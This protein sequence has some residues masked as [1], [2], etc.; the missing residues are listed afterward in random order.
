[1][2]DSRQIRFLLSLDG[3]EQ[4]LGVVDYVTGLFRPERLE[5]VLFHVFSAIPD[6]Y[7]DLEPEPAFTNK[8]I[9]TAVSES[10]RRDAV[11]EFMFEAES[12]VTE[13]GLPGRAIKVK[14]QDRMQDVARD[15]AY[16]AQD[17]YLA[18]V[19]GGIGTTTLQDLTVGSTA[20]KLL[21][22]LTSVNMIVVKGRP[23]PDRVLLAY[24]GSEGSRRALNLT[25]RLLS[26]SQC[27]ITVFHAL[28]GNNEDFP[29]NGNGKEVRELWHTR[30]ADVK[31]RVESSLEQAREFLEN[32]GVSPER[33]EVKMVTGVASRSGAIFQEALK[34]GYGSIIV[35][36]KGFSEVNEFSMG[37]VSN[38]LIH[39]ARNMAVWVAA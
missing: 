2:A 7:W 23:A 16:E 11:R 1:M 17:G 38:K 22:H 26:D 27:R 13:A 9:R 21:D 10:R 12:R 37:R 3:S 15:I 24:D 8:I 25:A 5:V 33:L 36:R 19:M 30:R 6:D 34:V 20:N 29:A 31:K 39:L 18:L 28:R 14:V 35:G 32:N 4:S